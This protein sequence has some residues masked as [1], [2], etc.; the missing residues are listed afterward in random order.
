MTTAL[1]IL[2]NCTVY[3]NTIKLP[4]QQFDRPLYT[5]I[6]KKISG[7]GG[8][9]KGGNIRAFVFDQD[10]SL[11]L[12]AL[13]QGEN[14]NFKKEYQIFETP[15][16]VADR[17]IDLA[18]L[19]SDHTV[20]EPSAGTGAIIRRIKTKFP[21]MP[22]D[23][24]EIFELNQIKLATLPGVKLIGSDF[25]KSNTDI[26]YDRVIA[27][28]PFSKNQDIKHIEQMFRLLK[29]GGRLVSVCS[30]HW[31]M[32]RGN[33]ERTFT[34]WFELMGGKI[35]NVEHGAFRQ[36][37]TMIETRIITLSKRAS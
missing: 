7:I 24:Y 34:R 17:L 22:V 2:Q 18:G 31:M 5:E 14:I 28:P 25:L 23:A 37:G 29:P 4:S 9:W 33:Y 19:E 1:E 30:P 8:K 11:Y 6:A 26:L 15:V 27:N 16:S 35:F 10:P 21:D 3:G 13:Q 32:A 20:L 36:S 12:Q